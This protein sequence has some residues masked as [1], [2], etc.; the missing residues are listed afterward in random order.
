MEP[1]APIPATKFDVDK[2]AEV[3]RVGYPAVEPL[4]PQILEW[5]KDLN[6]PVSRV[7]QPFL[8]SIGAPLAPHVEAVLAGRDDA[9]KHSVLSGVVARSPSLA[10]ALTTQLKRLADA[11]SPGESQEEVDRVAGEILD[12]LS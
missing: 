8:A 12:G 2:A 1:I 7:L 4:I 10:Q 6:W 11:P 3:V 9:W 5:I